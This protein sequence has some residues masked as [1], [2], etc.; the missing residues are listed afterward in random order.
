MPHKLNH[1]SVDSYIELMHVALLSHEDLS[2][3]KQG[4]S[5]E[6]QLLYGTSLWITYLELDRNPVPVQVDD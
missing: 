6:D 2:V 3:H 1:N 5:Y 4:S